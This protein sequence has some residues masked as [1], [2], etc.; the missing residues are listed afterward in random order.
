MPSGVVE[1][2]GQSV[3]GRGDIHAGLKQGGGRIVGA[4]YTNRGDVH[5]GLGAGGVGNCLESEPLGGVRDVKGRDLDVREIIA[6][7]LRDGEEGAVDLE[8]AAGVLDVVS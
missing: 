1:G 3:D 6:L 8:R 5:G 2:D 7:H 4:E